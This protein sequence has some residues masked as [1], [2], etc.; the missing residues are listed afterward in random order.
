MQPRH[1]QCECYVLRNLVGLLR[2]IT[3]SCALCCGKQSFF[4]MR[5]QSLTVGSSPLRVRAR[6]SWHFGASAGRAD[7]R[8]RD[9]G[10]VATSPRSGKAADA[11]PPPRPA[12]LRP[13][14]HG[15]LAPVCHG[16]HNVIVTPRAAT[17]CQVI[18]ARALSVGWAH[19]V[20]KTP[21]GS[22]AG[23][24]GRPRQPR[25]P[26]ETTREVAMIDDTKQ[27]PLKRNRLQEAIEEAERQPRSERCPESS[28]PNHEK[29][30]SWGARRRFRAAL[31]KVGRFELVDSHYAA[32]IQNAKTPDEMVHTLIGCLENYPEE[33]SRSDSFKT[34][35]SIFPHLSAQLLIS[36]QIGGHLI[37]K[38]ELDRR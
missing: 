6:I 18:L 32:R 21:L 29:A 19:N 16:G 2:I 36:S 8:R 15:T 7:A 30:D 33:A 5:F 17:K 13:P 20:K 27:D 1:R 9:A 3:R 34:G 31:E 37:Q 11:R 25:F 35:L 38:E 12:G 22:K 24:A 28:A 4:F 23:E 14:G 10:D 26:P